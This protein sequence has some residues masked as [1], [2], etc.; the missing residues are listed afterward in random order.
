MRR[1]F[2]AQF[3]RTAALGFGVLALFNG[4]LLSHAWLGFAQARPDYFDEGWPTFSRA[5]TIGDLQLYRLLAGVA[6]GGLL[7]GAAALAVM[8]WQR[9]RE[10]P[11]ARGTLR[12]MA[13]GAAVASMLGIVHYFH[14][15]ITLSMNNDVHMAMSYLFFFGMSFMILVDLVCAVRIRRRLPPAAVDRQASP[16]HACGV[17]LCVVGIVFLIT[18]VL[19]D[20]ES[21]PWPAATQRVFVAAEWGWIVLAHTYAVL[22][23]PAVR[24]HFGRQLETPA[25]ADALKGGT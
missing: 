1:Y 18:Y 23:F 6:G 9:A 11:L 10:H 8:Q 2:S 4:L 17:T 21:N 13:L 15:A 12:V 16:R 24:A 14:V 19:K 7:A 3:W 22:Y 25:P 20:V 5:L